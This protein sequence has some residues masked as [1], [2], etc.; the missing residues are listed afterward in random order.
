MGGQINDYEGKGISGDISADVAT[1]KEIF[2]K[3]SV[4]RVREF[5]CGG[6]I[7]ADCAAFYFD[8]MVNAALINDSIIKPMVGLG[9]LPPDTDGGKDGNGGAGGGTDLADLILRRVLYSNEAA[10]TDDMA[11][12]LR[13][14]LY[15]DTLLLIDTCRRALILNTKGWK[16]RGISEPEDERILEGPREGFEEA[17]MMNPHQY[18]PPPAE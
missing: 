18:G 17:V 4:L 9:V 12:M 10:A 5:H 3:D 13:G 15:G 8:G 14:M 11:E 1:L 2:A 16:T 7:D 6:D